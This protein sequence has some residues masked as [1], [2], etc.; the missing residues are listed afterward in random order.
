[1]KNLELNRTNVV[2][3]PKSKIPILRSWTEPKPQQRRFFPI[4]KL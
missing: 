4:S 1:V 2:A 3:E